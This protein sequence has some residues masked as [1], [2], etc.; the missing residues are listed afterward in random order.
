[1]EKY[2]NTLRAAGKPFEL[3]SGDHQTRVN[4]CLQIIRKKFPEKFS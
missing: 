1:L 3:I 4:T 2:K